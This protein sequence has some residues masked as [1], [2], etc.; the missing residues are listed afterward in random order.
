MQEWVSGLDLYLDCAD[1]EGETQDQKEISLCSFQ[2]L[3]NKVTACYIQ[4]KGRS[5]V[6]CSLVAARGCH[7]VFFLLPE[8]F[9]TIMYLHSLQKAMM[10]AWENLNGKIG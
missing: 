4:A 3:S 6:S 7:A 2:K 5:I 1:T 10:C 9:Q 8:C